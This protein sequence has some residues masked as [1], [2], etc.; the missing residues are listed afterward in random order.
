MIKKAAFYLFL[1]SLPFAASSQSAKKYLSSAQKFQKANDCEQAL[2]NFSKSIELDPNNGKAYVGRAECYEQLKKRE[3][4]A[5][6][7]KRATAF[8]P[9]DAEVFFNA[10]RVFYEIANYKEADVFFKQAIEKDKNYLEAVLWRIKTLLEL[11]NYEEGLVLADMALSDKKSALNYYNHAIMLDSLQ[12][13]EMAVKS[14]DRA[15]FYD[16]KFLEAYVGLIIGYARIDKLDK[17]VEIAQKALEKE[18]DEVK[19]LETRSKAYVIAKQYQKATNDLTDVLVKKPDDI[20]TFY[21][22]A[23]CLQHLEQ[24]QHAINDYKKII[25]IDPNSVTAYTRK[26]F[27][28]EQ[29]GDIKAAAAAYERVVSLAPDDVKMKVLLEEANKKLFEINRERNKPEILLTSYK[30]DAKNVIE[31][32]GNAKE[33]LIKGKVTDESKI[34]TIKVEHMPAEYNAD[35]I[36]PVFALKVRVDEKNDVKVE[37]KDVYGNERIAV[38]TLRRTEVDPP[39][40]KLIAP[41]ASDNGEV[42][43]SSN[44]PDLYVEGK[45]EDE[46]YI[47][48]INIEGANASFIVDQKNPKFSATINISNKNQF[49]VKAVDK[50][51]NENLQLFKINREGAMIS[52]NNPMGKTWVIFIE[53]ANYMNFASLD[54]P[55]KDITMMKSAFAKYKV[56]NV[57]HK[58]NMSKD[59]LEK[60]FSIEL[61]DLVKSNRVNSLLVWYAGH[62]KFINETGY[63]IPVD[64]KRDEEFTYFNINNLK[65][66]FQGYSKYITHTLV[67]TDA[68]ESGPSFY[69]AMRATAQER[70]CDDWQA[71]KFK[72]SQVFSSAGYELASDDSQFTRTFSNT[73]ANNPDACIPI[74]NI[75][76]KVK[77]AVTKNNQQS[78]KFGKIAGLEDENGTF[79]FIKK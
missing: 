28:H 42:Y 60:F 47:T 38:Y 59:D 43:L 6:D 65:A 33:I 40:I 78:P 39:K 21:K 2:S 9:K 74:D 23:S 53:N 22:R 52:E 75:V 35:T 14:Y 51:G 66:S 4:A 13:H 48:S 70:R 25:K 68:C 37:V 27:C 29:L 76:S 11:K 30:A 44:D 1:I 5:E 26:A 73:L 55:T 67:I 62:G 19:V 58:K 46:S 50:Y 34:K 45:I 71:T 41:Y 57:I 72:S 8:F 15:V 12:K 49:A 3:E 18:L 61:R 17:A 7:Y 64:A 79:F 36:N 63:W 24:Y 10:G 20:L 32:A 56:H 31:I 77:D 54:G 69:Q 16:S